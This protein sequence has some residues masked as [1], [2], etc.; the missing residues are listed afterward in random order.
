MLRTNGQA[1]RA[2]DGAARGGN[3]AKVSG[4]HVR[5]RQSEAVPVSVDQA[6]QVSV[7]DQVGVDHG[8][9]LEP[10][11]REAFEDDRTDTARSDDADVGASEAC[12]CV[13]APAVD[14]AYQAWTASVG[15]VRAR[16]AIRLGAARPDPSNVRTVGKRDLAETGL[17]PEASA[18]D[19]VGAHR[20]AEQRQACLPNEG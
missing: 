6:I 12:L 8:D 15:R 17:L 10:G 11:A 5:L 14:G 13:D 16:S 19:A 4:R 20:E 1:H 2:D 18:P 9:L 7:F 3:S